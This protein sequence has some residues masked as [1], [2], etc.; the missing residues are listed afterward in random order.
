MFWIVHICLQQ[1]RVDILS[2]ITSEILEEQREKALE[3]LEPFCF[4]YLS[5]IMAA[6]AYLMSRNRM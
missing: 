3:G 5:E 2:T 6:G 1:F 4:D